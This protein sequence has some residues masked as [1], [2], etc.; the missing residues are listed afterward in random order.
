MD[1]NRKRSCAGESV[2]GNS[3]VSGL[4]LGGFHGIPWDVFSPTG[5]GAQKGRLFRVPSLVRPVFVM[6]GRCVSTEWYK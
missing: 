6:F 5:F 1:T 3:G 2:K 4:W